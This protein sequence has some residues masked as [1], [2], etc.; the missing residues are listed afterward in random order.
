[1]N[2][3]S[4]VS[5]GSMLI[6]VTLLFRLDGM[7]NANADR[8]CGLGGARLVSLTRCGEV[9][10]AAECVLAKLKRLTNKASNILWYRS[11]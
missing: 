2:C 9:V 5:L 10:M 4:Y 7:T 8:F 1:M 11:L 3:L 6:G